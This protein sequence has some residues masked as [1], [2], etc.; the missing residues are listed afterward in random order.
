MPLPPPAIRRPV[1]RCPGRPEPGRAQRSPRRP[2]AP[3]KRPGPDPR[4]G[5]GSAN[6][7][8]AVVGA[9]PQRPRPGPPRVLRSYGTWRM[10]WISL[11]FSSG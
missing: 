8:D 9:G 11:Q 5:D 1:G 3:R 2:A 7:T 6:C 4:P 10:S